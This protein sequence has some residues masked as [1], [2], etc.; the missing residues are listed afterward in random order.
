MKQHEDYCNTMVDTNAPLKKGAFFITPHQVL[1]RPLVVFA[2]SLMAGIIY[3]SA[4]KS[5]L[6][7]GISSIFLFAAL[8]CIFLLY[9]K[10]AFP[11]FAYLLAGI[12]LFYSVGG[13]EY[14]YMTNSITTKYSAFINHDV[15]IDGYIASEPQIGETKV[16]YVV[17]TQS[18]KYLGKGKNIKGKILLSIPLDSKRSEL[19]YGRNIYIKGVLKTPKGRRNPG[20]FDYRSYL[21]QSGISAT[22]FAQ[23]SG[24]KVI[25]GNSG[26]VIVK[27]GLIVRNH[28]IGIVNK[29][30][31]EQQAGLLNGMLIGYTD[32]LTEDVQKA[33]RD[34][35][36][37]HIMAVSGANVAFLTIP[38]V[39]VFRK[40]RVRQRTANILI[41]LILVMFVFVTGFEAS[42][43]R[44]VIMGITVLAAQIIR[45]ETDVFTSISFAAILLLVQ[46]PLN[47]FNIGFQLS[48]AATLS[49]IL[50][51]GFIKEKLDYKYIPG[52]ITDTMA[53]TLAAQVGVLPISAYY[54]NSVSI[55]S[56][57]SNLFVVP[58]TGIITVIGC[59]MAAAGVISL[60][61]AQIIGY[62]N[63]TLLFFILYITKTSASIP[64]AA[65]R[66]KTPSLLMI[67]AYYLLVIYFLWFKPKFKPE[68]KLK[69][70]T[71]C[72]AVTVVIILITLLLPGKLKVVFLDVGEGDSIFIKTQAGRN[73]LIDGGGGS[74]GISSGNNTGENIL[75]P[76]LLDEG[77]S[78]LDMVIA[79][80]GHDDHIQGLLPVLKQYKVDNLVI[81][82]LK[83]NK[84]L[85]TLLEIA[86]DKKI[87]VRECST[88]DSITLDPETEFFVL[89]PNEGFCASEE[90]LN[91]G[92]LVLKLVYNNT[93]LL[94]TGDIGKE[95]ENLL[96]R[97]KADIR[98]DVLKVAHHGS[99]GST[100][101]EFLK[102][103]NPKAAVIS[104]GTNTFGHPS[105]PVVNLIKQH[106][107]SLFTTQDCGA[108]IL[109]SD[110]NKFDIYTMVR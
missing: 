67:V 72:T 65:V 35:G 17:R 86:E 47:L 25:N 70:Y 66:I 33:F 75:I 98:A 78:K 40:L 19:V 101:E 106:E 85:N 15:G 57:I 45:R 20:S 55:I 34:A 26:N 12:M 87:K 39:F 2:V 105:K 1:R 97:G 10:K 62:I 61:L 80:H 83:D 93:S 58:L 79:T 7:I 74:N 9:N 103:V 110:G 92:S 60:M 109:Q 59:I 6:L 4:C 38:L 69:H 102:N 8:L 14:F 68:V 28:I 31:P 50:F 91:E 77:V 46:N 99:A 24:V 81:P 49:I 94:F 82:E 64:F 36:L 41:S 53:V 88:G 27:A 108:V 100:G 30:L 48:F 32:G 42:V 51:Y 76:F 3:A 73:I 29:S 22:I 71:V 96:L 37:S 84:E 52:F 43:T 16:S 44:A 54:F 107:I 104:V 56:V 23:G 21:A 95:T 18:I 13:F 11:G 90:Y 89:N 63:N 5:V